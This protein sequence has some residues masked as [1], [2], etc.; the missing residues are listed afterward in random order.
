[1]PSS[2]YSAYNIHTWTAVPIHLQTRVHF[3]SQWSLPPESIFETKQAKSFAYLDNHPILGSS[4]SHKHFMFFR[5]GI[6]D[7]FFWEI[8][9]HQKL[10]KQQ[11]REKHLFLTQHIFL[12]FH[13]HSDLQMP[14][15][16]QEYFFLVLLPLPVEQVQLQ[17]ASS[18]LGSLAHHQFT[19]FQPVI[20]VQHPIRV[21]GLLQCHRQF[22][23]GSWSCTILTMFYMYN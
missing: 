22:K 20:V 14:I 16:P 21:L 9:N 18:Y 2:L 12:D 17:N 11:T 7:R 6:W 1:M 10:T 3:K 4:L 5:R 19:T 15:L 8:T 23:W 13:K